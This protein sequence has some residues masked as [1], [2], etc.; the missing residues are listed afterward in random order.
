M[1][2][3]THRGSSSPMPRHSHVGDRGRVR[4]LRTGRSWFSCGE[5]S[6]DGRDKVRNNLHS[7]RG[8]RT[9]WDGS[10]SGSPGRGATGRQGCCLQALGVRGHVASKRPSHDHIGSDRKPKPQGCL[11]SEVKL[12]SEGTTLTIWLVEVE[13]SS[14]EFRS[15]GRRAASSRNQILSSA[16]HRCSGHGNSLATTGPNPL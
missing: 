2:R 10:G 15:V 16:H 6:P 9:S 14:E 1:P 5:N 7:S 13:S 8:H 12:V 11:R 3:K 4:G